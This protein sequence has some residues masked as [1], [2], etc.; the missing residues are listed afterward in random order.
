MVRL[1]LLLFFHRLSRREMHFCRIL[2]LERNPNKNAMPRR[3]LA[4]G[5]EERKMGRTLR[6]RVVFDGWT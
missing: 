4:K 6:G 5:F 1:S 3:E 2:I